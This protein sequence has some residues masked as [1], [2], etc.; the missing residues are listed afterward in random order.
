MAEQPW[1]SCHPLKAQGGFWGLV[2]AAKKGLVRVLVRAIYTCTVLSYAD[3]LSLI[4]IN[5][6][7]DHPMYLTRSG[8]KMGS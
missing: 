5:F 8:Q 4:K 7:V 3:M 6:T 2:M 1:W